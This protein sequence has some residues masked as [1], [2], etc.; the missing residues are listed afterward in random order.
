MIQINLYNTNQN[1]VSSH[2]VNPNKSPVP[3]LWSCITAMTLCATPTPT[4]CQ[5]AMGWTRA[6]CPCSLSW[7]RMSLQMTGRLIAGSRP[8][9]RG[10]VRIHSHAST[11]FGITEVSLQYVYSCVHFGDQ[12]ADFLHR[13]SD[14]KII[15]ASGKLPNV[16]HS[17]V[18]K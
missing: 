9:C 16:L 14:L 8:N 1:W 15:K 5:D 12:S 3:I 4:L 18:P 17:H 13:L 6:L 7:W 2:C 10:Q 11:Y